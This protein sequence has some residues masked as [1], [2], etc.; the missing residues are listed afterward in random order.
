[1]PVLPRLLARL[2]NHGTMNVLLRRLYQTHK[3][4]CAIAR[5]LEALVVVQV[6]GTVARVTSANDE[7]FL[8]KVSRVACHEHVQRGLRRAVDRIGLWFLTSVFSSQPRPVSCH[9]RQRTAEP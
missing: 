4:L 5:V 1:M 8:A 6:G 7:A 9:L 2:I 3:H